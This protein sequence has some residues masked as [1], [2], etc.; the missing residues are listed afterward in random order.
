MTQ[1]I[2]VVDDDEVVRLTLSAILKKEGFEVDV[3]GNVTSAI[4]KMREKDFDWII[5]DIRMPDV[6]GIGFTQKVKELWPDKK[7]ILM[8]GYV[9]PE[10]VN[11]LNIEGF[12]E[13]PIDL[14]ALISVIRNRT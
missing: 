5:S 12:F 13:K 3:A 2:I 1:S 11:G 8:S 9:R 10:Q 7:I 6:D 4:S 14:P